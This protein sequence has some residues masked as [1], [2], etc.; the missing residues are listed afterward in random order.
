MAFFINSL[1]AAVIFST[2]LYYTMAT[3]LVKDVYVLF[4]IDGYVV[5]SLC[6]MF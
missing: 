5:V 2:V 4:G 1:A 3:L 6:W